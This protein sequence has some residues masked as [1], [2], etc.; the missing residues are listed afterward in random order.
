MPDGIKP[1]SESMLIDLQLHLVTFIRWSHTRD[2]SV[3]DNDNDSDSDS[4]SDSDFIAMN[5]IGH[6]IGDVQASS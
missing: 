1:L 4:D 5:Y 3:N 6:I 2:T